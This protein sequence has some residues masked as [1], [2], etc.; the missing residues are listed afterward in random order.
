MHNQGLH[1]LL[2]M[3]SSCPGTSASSAQHS[4]PGEVKER[5]LKGT[6]SAQKS[7]QRFE[8]ETSELLGRTEE[9]GVSLMGVDFLLSELPN[10]W[11]RAP[12][13]VAIFWGFSLIFFT[14]EGLISLKKR[15]SPV[16]TSNSKEEKTILHEIKNVWL[17]P[18]LIPTWLFDVDHDRTSS[19][20]H[21]RSTHLD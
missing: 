21:H 19:L 5:P 8:T 14:K 2:L 15:M 11:L 4:T 6:V 13:L 18:Y 3:V 12:F 1:Y 17:W 7:V 9:N 16:G 20:V 10:I